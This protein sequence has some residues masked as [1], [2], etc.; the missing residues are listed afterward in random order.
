LELCLCVVVVGAVVDVVLGAL[1]VEVVEELAALPPHPATATPL[2]STASVVSM[3][4]SGALL[5][6]RAP[7]VACGLGRSP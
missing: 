7:F 5:I 4:V 6:G 3:A 2:A 1:V